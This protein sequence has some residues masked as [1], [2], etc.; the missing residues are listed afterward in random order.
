MWHRIQRLG[1]DAIYLLVHKELHCFL[2]ALLFMN[3]NYSVR[4]RPA[5]CK[6]LVPCAYG[7]RTTRQMEKIPQCL[8]PKPSLAIAAKRHQINETRSFTS[9]QMLCFRN[10]DTV[11]R[12]LK[13][14]PLDSPHFA[15]SGPRSPHKLRALKQTKVGAVFAQKSGH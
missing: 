5:A 14:L 1:Q 2:V 15:V 7:R 9:Q 8:Q 12:R 4:T 3:D 6:V 13:L 11:N 10:N